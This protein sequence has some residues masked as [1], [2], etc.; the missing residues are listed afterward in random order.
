MSFTISPEWHH[1][2]QRTR[3]KDYITA[4]LSTYTTA[5]NDATSTFLPITAITTLFTYGNIKIIIDKA[6]SLPDRIEFP[7]NT[8]AFFT[9]TIS[10]SCPR[11]FAA[12]IHAGL[13][14][15]F[16]REL[17]NRSISDDHEFPVSDTFHMPAPF[18][19][20]L[21]V[22]KSHQHKSCAPVLTL[23]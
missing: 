9:Q 14:M 5:E 1:T 6:P 15:L 8:R 20:D 10:D 3:C 11:I 19:D 22:F 21:D 18:A 7:D 16:L 12:C 4:K 2:E 17:W 13:S 23:G